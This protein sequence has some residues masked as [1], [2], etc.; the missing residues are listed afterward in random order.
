[1]GHNGY[2]ILISWVTIPNNAI[3]KIKSGMAVICVDS[4]EQQ[5]TQAAG[6]CA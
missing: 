6:Y 3:F 5:I 4:G 2:T 1:M